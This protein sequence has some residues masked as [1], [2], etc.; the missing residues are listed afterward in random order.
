MVT[1]VGIK[2]WISIVMR[3]LLMVAFALGAWN[4]KTT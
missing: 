3:L 2:F 4:K 1:D